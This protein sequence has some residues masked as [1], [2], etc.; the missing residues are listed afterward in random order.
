VRGGAALQLCLGLLAG[1]A[2]I[3]GCV[4]RFAEL[5][6]HHQDG[7]VKKL[8]DPVSDESSCLFRRHST[9]RAALMQQASPINTKSRANN[10]PALV[11]RISVVMVL[12]IFINQ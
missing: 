3:A 10:T 9:N 8:H 2:L 4:N 5:D 12:S 7:I 1:G 6:A 11:V